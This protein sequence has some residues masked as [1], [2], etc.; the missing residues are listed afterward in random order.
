[1]TFT[2]TAPAGW[3]RNLIL[4]GL[5]APC[6]VVSAVAAGQLPGPLVSVQW[7]N[8]HQS[9]VQIVDVRDDLNSL[10]AKP[11]YDTVDG[12]Q[13]LESVGGHIMDALSVNFWGLRTEQRVEGKTLDFQL[14]PRE[15]FQA[16]MRGVQLEAGKPIVIT[17]T[18]DDPTSLQEAALYAWV[19]QV[20]GVPAEQVAILNGGVHAW[21]AA[22]LPIDTDAIAPLGSTQWEAKPA[23]ADMVATR[24]DVQKAQ[25]ARKVL[26]DTRPLTQFAGVVQPPAG[27]KPGRLAGSSSLPS[28]LLYKQA[29]D[30]SWHFLSAEENKALFAVKGM[31]R[32][33]PGIVYCNT[34][35]YAAG[36]WFMMERVQGIK[37]VRVFPGGIYEW[38]NLGMPL[39]SL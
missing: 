7:L 13:V 12:K 20:Y 15:E 2:M 28:E 37:G 24:E 8:E 26:V 32:L 35:Q 18:G 23:R 33:Q 14:V 3:W 22:G 19:L 16:R 6:A 9:E 5:L 29:T 17:P 34:G 39:E 36:A 11:S 21:I 27:L 4:A 38:V 1:M 31:P 30:G 25:K 10:T